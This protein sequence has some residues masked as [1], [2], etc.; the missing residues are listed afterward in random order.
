MATQTTN[1]KLIKPA[2]EDFYDV[3]E[4][5]GNADIIDTQ[6]KTLSN[7]KVDKVSGKGLS[8]N[9]YTTAEKNKLAGIATG[10]NNYVHPATHPWSMI[11]GAPT[12]LPASGG[13]A[14]K[15]KNK[16]TAGSKTYDGSAAVTL[17]AA[18]LGAAPA[19]TY[20]TTDLTP[21]TSSLE[22]GKIYLVYE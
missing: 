15:V 4:F 13:T 7:N 17:T 11:T 5:N 16:L 10:A 2:Q 8:T 1:Y 18:D 21:G 3:D 20:S 6:L 12:S 19:Y 9:D 14:D 22:T